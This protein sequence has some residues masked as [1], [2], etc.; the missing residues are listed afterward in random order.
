[1]TN[2]LRASLVA[3]GLFSAGTANADNSVVVINQSSYVIHSLY[4][5]P[6][7]S[8]EWGP[9]QLGEDVIPPGGT[10]TFTGIH[11]GTYDVRLTNPSG[12]VCDVP[13]VPICSGAEPWVL[14]DTDLE[15]CG[16]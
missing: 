5:S 10:M 14:T 2:I 7:A 9:D 16:Q 11:C 3:L 15:A 1:M 13:A 6:T 12:G 8:D 4:I